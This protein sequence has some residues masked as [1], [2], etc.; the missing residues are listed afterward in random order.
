MEI[1]QERLEREFNLSLLAT[2]PSVVY[3]VHKTDGEVLDVDNPANMPAP[4]AI[5][6][7]EEPY[8]DAMVI[9]PTEY[10]GAVME[11]GRERRGIF[12]RMEYPPPAASCSTTNCLF[13]RS[14]WTFSTS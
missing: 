8:V 12:G 1:V 13:P 6:H 2:A 10:V 11:M 9:V 5:E 7:I 14:S 3:K 4:T